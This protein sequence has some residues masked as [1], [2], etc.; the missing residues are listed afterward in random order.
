[1]SHSTV[2]AGDPNR[3]RI[4]DERW[5]LTTNR[6]SGGV[7]ATQPRIPDGVGRRRKGA[8]S[9]TA[10]SRAAYAARRPDARVPGG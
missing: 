6:K 2:S 3:P 1:M 5:A 9:S 4:A 7:A 10:G 8:F